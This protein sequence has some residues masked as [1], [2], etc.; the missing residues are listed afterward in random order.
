MIDHAWTYRT[1]D[2]RQILRAN[3]NLLERVCTMMNVQIEEDD[4]SLLKDKKIEGVFQKMW[5]YNQTY[6]IATDKLV[7][8]L[9]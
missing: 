6:K 8:I 9:L 5:K 2:A 4:E 3:D 7:I 1:N